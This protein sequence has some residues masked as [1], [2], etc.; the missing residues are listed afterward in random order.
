MFGDIG[1]FRGRGAQAIVSG[2]AQATPPAPFYFRHSSVIL[3][4][5]NMERRFRH[6][7]GS[8]TKTLMFRGFFKGGQGCR[9]RKFAH[10][11][12]TGG[13]ISASKDEKAD[14]DFRGASIS[15]SIQWNLVISL[16]HIKPCM[17][18]GTEAMDSAGS[19]R[20]PGE[21]SSHRRGASAPMFIKKKDEKR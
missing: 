9:R 21:Q 11:V 14:W 4:R 10:R 5:A 1:G 8:S 20:G 17:K 6:S 3:R 16:T 7:R 15:V 18:L 12:E 19:N 13:L 2:T